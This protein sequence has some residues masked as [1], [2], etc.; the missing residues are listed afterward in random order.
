MPSVS[1]RQTTC[2]QW[3]PSVKF[4][5]VRF[6]IKVEAKEQ[7]E[8]LTWWQLPLAVNHKFS[9]A[10]VWSIRKLKNEIWSCLAVCFFKSTFFFFFWAGHCMHPKTTIERV[11]K[12]G[13]SNPATSIFKS[14]STSF[15]TPLNTSNNQLR[16]WQRHV[17]SNQGPHVLVNG[18]YH[19]AKSNQHHLRTSK[20]LTDIY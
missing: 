9:C 11:T 3:S 14:V 4:F 20:K 2:L 7:I 8:T 1:I 10:Q 19:A 13:F 18:I 16:F 12:K 15:K 5:T 17:S 6:D